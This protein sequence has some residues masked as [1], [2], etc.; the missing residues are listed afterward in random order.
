[1][2]IGLLQG[3]TDL[4][5][6]EIFSSDDIDIINKGAVAEAFVGSE[7]LKNGSHTRPQN[8]Y[9]WRREDK[10]GNA[11]V[12]FVVQIGSRIVPIEVRSVTR[13][14]TQSIRIFM[15]KKRLNYGICTSLENF[16]TTGNIDVYPLYAI[17]N[18][19]QNDDPVI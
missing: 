11:Q 19:L 10:K 2:E 7:L 12:D 15:A 4:D 3:L 14:S 9:C 13:G 5:L 8:L 1:L 18:V 6:S 16:K 17:G